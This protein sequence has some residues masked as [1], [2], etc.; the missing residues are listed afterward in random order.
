MVDV[1]LEQAGVG[2]EADEDEHAANRKL[3]GR[4]VLLVLQ[5]LH[6][7]VA[8]DLLD[9]G[10]EDELDLWVRLRAIDEDRLGPQLVAAGRDVDLGGAPREGLALLDPRVAAPRP[11]PPL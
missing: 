9:T 2:H 3:L 1:E 11:G 4:A 5:R 8:D 6:L 10:I 7:A